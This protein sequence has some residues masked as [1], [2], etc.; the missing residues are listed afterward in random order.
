[1]QLSSLN[2]RSGTIPP[3]PQISISILLAMVFHF[4][5]SFRAQFSLISE[6]IKCE[7]DTEPQISNKIIHEVMTRG[8][9]RTWF[10]CI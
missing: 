6:I 3:P 5:Q 10:A 8:A 2:S 4:H 7:S 1:M 9:R